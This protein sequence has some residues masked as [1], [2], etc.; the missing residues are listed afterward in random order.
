MADRGG[1]RSFFGHQD[2]SGDGVG[3]LVIVDSSAEGYACDGAAYLL[4]GPVLGGP[5]LDE[6]WASYSCGSWDWNHT[7]AVTAQGEG[8][9]LAVH[10]YDLPDSVSLGVLVFAT[11]EEGSHSA[12]DAD[13]L[14]YGTYYQTYY[15]ADLAPGGDVDGDGVDDLLVGTPNYRSEED[16]PGTAYLLLG[17]VSGTA[18]LTDA[19]AV[20]E[21]ENE[22]DLAGEE[23]VIVGDTAGDGTRDVAVGAFG[24]DGEGEGLGRVYLFLQPPEGAVGLDQAD[25]IVSGLERNAWHIEDR[26]LGSAIAGGDLDGDGRCD[27]VVSSPYSDHAPDG[28]GSIYAFLGPLEGQLTPDDAAVVLYCDE[29]PCSGGYA[30][31]GAVDVDGDGQDDLLVGAPGWG[32]FEPDNTEHYTPMP[33]GVFLVEGRQLF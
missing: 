32:Q 17:P 26:G 23:V 18:P 29:T 24:W 5:E 14:R 9:S 21:G 11:L 10:S 2:A 12:D 8:M 19:R 33:G 30:L 22:G 15:A 3:D 16:Q 6:A 25:A 28:S 1:I 4:E 27:L 7:I 13:A 31:D 20:F